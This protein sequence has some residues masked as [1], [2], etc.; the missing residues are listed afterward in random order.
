MLVTALE[1][2]SRAGGGVRVRVDGGPFATVAL[3]DVRGLGLAVGVELDERRAA[4]VEAR[5]EAFAARTV[6]VRLLAGQSLPG[7]ELFRRLTR[8]SHAPEVAERVVAALVAE[9]LVNDAEFARTFARSRAARRRYG[10][11]RIEADLRRMGVDRRLASE[12]VAESFEREGLDPRAL[13]QEAVD[14]KVASLA[15]LSPD[16]RRRRLR[17]YLVRRGFPSSDIIEALRRHAR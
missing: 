6:A 8:K 11:S 2:E 4:E 5:A 9:G 3:G 10:P 16:V 7:R 13:L 17:A 1:V 14:K 15:G 12:A